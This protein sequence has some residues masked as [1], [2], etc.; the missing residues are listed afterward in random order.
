MRRVVEPGGFTV[1]VGGSSLGGVEGKFMVV[2]P[3]VMVA[4][5]PPRFR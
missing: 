2:G 4:P 3:V 1:W 5:A